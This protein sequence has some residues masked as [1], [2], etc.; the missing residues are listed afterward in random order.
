MSLDRAY[1][2]IL[3]ESVKK[4]LK[5]DQR[6]FYEITGSYIDMLNLQWIY[7]GKKYYNLSP[8]E[9]FNYTINKG[10][11]FDYRKIKEFCY[12]KNIDDFVAVSESTAYGFMFKSNSVNGIFMEREM[13]KYLYAKLK[14]ARRRFKLDISVILA[15]LEMINFEIRDII[16]II[17]N[18]R[19]GME[20]EEAKEYLIKVI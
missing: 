8:E 11:K 6:A 10:C 19:Y 2:V 20:Y 15:Y 9:L 17:E 13:H 16:S 12:C 4:L 3:E 14:H 7:R 5:P 18:V 1:F